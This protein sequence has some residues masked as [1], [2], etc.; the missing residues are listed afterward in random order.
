MNAKQVKKIRK[1]LFKEG[2]DIASIVYCQIGG[3]VSQGRMMYQKAKK[4]AKASPTI[5]SPYAPSHGVGV[6]SEGKASKFKGFTKKGEK[7]RDNYGDTHLMYEERPYRRLARE[8]EESQRVANQAFL[9]KQG[10]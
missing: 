8:L 2:I 6:P 7:W 9:P 4:D 3:K 1:D 10:D 5:L